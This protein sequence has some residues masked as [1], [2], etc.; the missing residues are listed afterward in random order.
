[1]ERIRTYGSIF[2]VKI[3]EVC[4]DLAFSS[5]R[6]KWLIALIHEYKF[7]LTFLPRKP[8]K[9]SKRVCFKYPMVPMMKGESS[10]KPKCH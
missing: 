3:F 1:M 4:L 5:M 9:I 10:S 7:I 2:R 6:L 8:Y